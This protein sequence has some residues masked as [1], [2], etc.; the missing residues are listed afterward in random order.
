MGFTSH[1]P[2]PERLD[3]WK[4]IAAYL[5]RTVRT[6]QRWEND[7]ALPVHRVPG[8]KRDM[9][10]AFSHE[11]AEWRR[12][13][14][15]LRAMAE[16]PDEPR[17]PAD[18]LLQSASAE[19]VTSRPGWSRIGMA[20]GLITLGAVSAALLWGPAKGVLA[21]LAP[22]AP[23]EVRVAGRQV[24]VFDKSG[25][26]LWAH[27]FGFELHAASY[28]KSSRHTG[29]ALAELHDLDGDGRNELLFVVRTPRTGVDYT[30][31]YSFN[32][33]GSIRFT[34]RRTDKVRFGDLEYAPPFHPRG[35]LVTPEADG[36]KT[37]WLA[38]MQTPE[39]PEVLEKLNPRGKLLG[40]FW[41]GGHLHAL[42]E[43]KYREKRVIF[44]GYCENDGRRAS[45]AVIDYGQPTGAAPAQDPYYECTSCPAGRP[46]AFF[47][48]PRAELSR[49]FNS[50]PRATHFLAAA[51][52]SLQVRVVQTSD[53]R[54]IGERESAVH[55]KLDGN[56]NFVDA[57]HDAGYGELHAQAEMRGGVK[58]AYSRAEE[59]HAF[60]VLR[61]DGSQFV[62]V[63]APAQFVAAR[64]TPTGRLSAND[65]VNTA[66]AA[67]LRRL[68]P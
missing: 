26:L 51:D 19:P 40:E 24:Q 53:F 5:G 22:P 21:R 39:F 35:F 18:S 36:T 13:R 61:W 8:R 67:T 33:D 55:Y 57:F 44:A 16:P 23:F 41:H 45:M 66:P 6:V 63:G 12:T 58:H 2:P 42:A 37:V 10:Y 59:V 28:E 38:I 3:S 4:E 52:G 54:E 1:S 14:E 9:V 7:L 65:A 32:S 48:F 15:G 27:D 43:G 25:R 62:K 64:K 30:E 29:P 46:L 50:M 17:A 49:L 11:L 60:P 20:L 47:I 34:R 68:S 31:F 56:L